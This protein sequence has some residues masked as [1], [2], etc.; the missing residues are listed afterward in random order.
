MD[1]P[2]VGD[3]EAMKSWISN[4]TNV[5]ATISEEELMA[6]TYSGC[7]VISKDT[8]LIDLLCSCYKFV[9][10]EGVHKGLL[11]EYV[12]FYF[13]LISDTACKGLPLEFAV[14][15]LK[16]RHTKLNCHFTTMFLKASID[17]ILMNL[18]QHYH[19]FM[20]AMCHERE[21]DERKDSVKVV[22]VHDDNISPL[23]TAIDIDT[24]NLQQSI[25][26]LEESN[27][28][29]QEEIVR[30]VSESAGQLES[31]LNSYL[32]S[33]TARM[34]AS[35]ESTAVTPDQVEPTEGIK[36]L[37]ANIV[38]VH[39]KITN[40]QLEGAVAR[41]KQLIQHEMAV[42]ALKRSNQKPTNEVNLKP[43]RAK[44][45]SA[46]SPAKKK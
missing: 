2:V 46:K 31:E 1:H 16:E 40:N 10:N 38:T 8:L 15:Q 45:G 34:E 28:S 27:K 37:I 19:L 21:K 24:W 5:P 12:L 33:L 9:Y 18:I 22:S 13:D 30:T 25:N 44:R 11:K 39:A 32:E 26:Q 14:T 20:F 23:S 17:F 4:L 35:E 36:N 6:H 43:S 41:S 3:D 29:N 42:N 7:T